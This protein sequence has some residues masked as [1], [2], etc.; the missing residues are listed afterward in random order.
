MKI[1]RE[2]LTICLLS[3]LF[4]APSHSA[5]INFAFEGMVTE[6]N[7]NTVFSIGQTIEGQFTYDSNAEDT[8]QSN[9]E[10]GDYQAIVNFSFNSGGYSVAADPSNSLNRSF[11][12]FRNDI[13]SPQEYSIFLLRQA[14]SSDKWGSDVNGEELIRMW[15]K[16][17]GGSQ[18]PISTIDLPLTAP[19]LS[20]F[21]STILG[22]FF[23]QDSTGFSSAGVKFTLTSI[24]QVPVPPTSQIPVP[25][26]IYLFLLALALLARLSQKKHNKQKLRVASYP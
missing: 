26:S 25:A 13:F 8:L 22:L 15:L 23:E 17:E 7:K 24:E 9:P 12:V 1:K 6:S 18:Q 14:G 11:T 3:I 16:L 5:L 4:S 2:I 20:S 10:I 19:N 21:D